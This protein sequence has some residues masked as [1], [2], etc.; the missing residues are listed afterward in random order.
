[1]PAEDASRVPRK[2]SNEIGNVLP[3]LRGFCD[4]NPMFAVQKLIAVASS[5][6]TLVAGP[7]KGWRPCLFKVV[8]AYGEPAW[9]RL[10]NCVA[11]ARQARADQPA[12]P[13]LRGIRK[14]VRRRPLC[15]LHRDSRRVDHERRLAPRAGLEPATL[16]LTAGCSAIELP[17]NLAGARAH[18]RD[19]SG[20]VRRSS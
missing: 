5:E 4:V 1:M 9:L 6:L 2:D 19:C 12:W 16:R 20:R 7:T 14:E 11:M 17:R 18:G 15:G 10:R 13:K 3:A 8:A